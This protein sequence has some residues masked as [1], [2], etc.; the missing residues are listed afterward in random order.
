MFTVSGLSIFLGF[1][2]HEN[3]QR[4]I[5]KLKKKK[6]KKKERKN[7]MKWNEMKW[8]MWKARVRTASN[9]EYNTMNEYNEYKS[10]LSP[11]E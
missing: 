3:L 5:K 6:K 7:E 4:K 1:E 10:L 11:H 9:F 8:K 2:K